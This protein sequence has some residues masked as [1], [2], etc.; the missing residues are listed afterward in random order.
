MQSRTSD[1]S[2]VDP[3]FR[4]VEGGGPIVATAIHAGHALRAEVAE[5]MAL[6]DRERR[7][8]E[9]PY[10]ELL[11]IP[12]A[13]RVLVDRSRFEVDLNRTAE[14]AIYL[15]EDQSW[16]L[17]VWKSPPSADLVNRSLA[18]HTD[19]YAHLDQVLDEIASEGP[20]VVLDL[21]SYN[22]RRDGVD[23]P[24]AP[25]ADNPDVNI[26]TGTLDHPRWGG[27][28]ERFATDLAARLPR[29]MTVAENVRFRGGYLSKRVNE[30][31][32]GRGC[33]LALEFK[34]TFV[35]EWTDELDTDALHRLTSALEATVDGIMAELNALSGLKSTT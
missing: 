27:L 7:R 25:L 15:T 3:P 19:F 11:T 20:F 31:Y 16:G 8:E 9:D 28:V 1:P 10:T 22:H 14:E 6:S 33:A 4:F 26:G 2:L 23:A 35:D 21:H 24:P 12:F 29:A 32:E 17:E 18:I 5:C 34:K 30:S 13:T